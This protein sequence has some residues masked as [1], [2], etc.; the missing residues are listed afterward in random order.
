M[1]RQRLV[2]LFSRVLRKDADG[3]IYLVTPIEKIEITVEAAPFLIVRVDRVDTDDGQAV[4][5]TTNFGD[6]VA[7]GP[8]HPLRIDLQDDG[9]PDPYVLVRGR[10]EGL[11]TRS[12]FYDL[13]DMAEIQSDEKG[14][15]QLVLRSHGQDFSLGAVSE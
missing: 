9:Q 3:K 8:D 13:V 10:L 15:D 2:H 14:V 4:V 5:C 1:T 6:H 11:F 12:A 7:I